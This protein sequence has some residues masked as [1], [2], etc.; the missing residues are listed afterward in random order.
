VCRWTYN[1]EKDIIIIL[2][3]SNRNTFVI[4]MMIVEMGLM[5]QCI[6]TRS[7]VV[8]RWSATMGSVFLLCGS[9]MEWTTVETIQ[10]RKT[11]VST[12][13]FENFQL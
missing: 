9:V 11:V 3:F 1:K 2:L 7:V 13:S 4:E 12:E 8:M 5:S 6:V 10:M